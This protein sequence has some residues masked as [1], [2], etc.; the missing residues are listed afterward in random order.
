MCLIMNGIAGVAFGWE[1]W[2]YGL[3]P[4]IVA[5]ASTDVV[6]HMLSRLIPATRA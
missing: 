2:R 1:Y 6:L 4:A 3:V 5:H